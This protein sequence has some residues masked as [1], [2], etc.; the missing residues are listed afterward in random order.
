MTFNCEDPEGVYMDGIHNSGIQMSD[1]ELRFMS[2]AYYYMQG[3]KSFEDVK[4]EGFCGTLSDDLVITFPAGTLLISEANYNG[5]AW[6]Q[7]NK[8]GEF[9]VDLSTANLLE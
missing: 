5:G 1:G 3:G 4:A 7:S 9:A 6:Y 2:M 8:T